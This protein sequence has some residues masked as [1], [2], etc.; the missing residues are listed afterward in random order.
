LAKTRQTNHFHIVLLSAAALLL[1]LTVL[2]AGISKKTEAGL[3]DKFLWNKEVAKAACDTSGAPVISI[4]QRVL[5]TV[6]SGEG[7]NNWAFDNVNRE[8][9]VYKQTENTYCVLTD[10]QGT[11]DS[12]SGQKSPGN[13]G[14]L[15]GKEDGTFKGGYR[16]II[17]GSMITTPGFPTKGNIGTV[18]YSCDISGTCPGAFSWVS[19]YFSPESIFSYDWWG[20][21]YKYKNLKWV[22]SSDGNKGDII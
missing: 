11:F 2:F 8:I 6:D 21:E 12:Q 5:N 14:T 18:D 22:N 19:K 7:G 9:K 4:K 17:T 16:A 13:T 10:Y 3:L 15:T 20:W 1:S